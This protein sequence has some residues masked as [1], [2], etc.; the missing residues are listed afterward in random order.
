MQAP[1]FRGCVVLVVQRVGKKKKGRKA[2]AGTYVAC[3]PCHMTSPIRTHPARQSRE[4]PV[5]SPHPIATPTVDDRPDM[6]GG[7]VPRPR[8]LF[9]SPPAAAQESDSRAAMYL[10]M[11]TYHMCKHDT[12]REGKKKKKAETRRRASR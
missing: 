1:S 2:V 6:Y 4:R 3:P 7:R 10:S 8:L 9:S 12:R 11:H 5:A